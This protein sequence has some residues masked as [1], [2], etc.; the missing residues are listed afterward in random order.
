MPLQPRSD[1]VPSRSAD[2]VIACRVSRLSWLW[3]L[4]RS[5]RIAV[6]LT[7]QCSHSEDVG[8]LAFCSPP[9]VALPL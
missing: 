7:R 8:G 3:S 6:D 1:A 2:N 5:E 4:V 9:T